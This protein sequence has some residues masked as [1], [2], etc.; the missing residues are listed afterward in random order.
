M[1]DTQVVGIKSYPLAL[2]LQ[3]EALIKELPTLN[4]NALPW[5]KYKAEAIN[6][7]LETYGA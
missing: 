5:V 1:S 3:M 6:K 4:T 7:E 2:A